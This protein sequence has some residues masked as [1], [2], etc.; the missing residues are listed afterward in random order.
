MRGPIAAT[1]AS[2]SR[3]KVA[4]SMSTKAGRAPGPGDRPGAREERERRRHHL[5][6]GAHARGDERQEERVAPGRDPDRVGGAQAR[7]D[8]L[9]EEAHLVAQDE[10]LSATTRF[11]RVADLGLDRT[12]LQL[13]SRG[14]EPC[15]VSSI[16]RVS[17]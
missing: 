15:E 10:G 6:A 9:L 8:G 12:V 7:G 11:D 16:R 4:A 5:V 2:A 14:E 17:P 3:V 1:A 13:A